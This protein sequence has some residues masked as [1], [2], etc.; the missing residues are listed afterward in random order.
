MNFDRICY[1][2]FQ[3]KEGAFCSQCGFAPQYASQYPQAL[4][5]G[6]ILGGRYITGKV[7][8]VDS[9]AISYLGYELVLEIKVVIREYF[10][11]RLA[12]RG[13]DRYAVTVS[14]D[15]E[16]TFRAGRQRFLDEA[17]ALAGIQS[18]PGIVSVR[19]QFEENNTAYI[20]TDHKEEGIRAANVP[21]ADAVKT[22]ATM[23]VPAGNA[24]AQTSYVH[25]GNAA[26]K[27]SFF[28]SL[29]AN[30]KRMALLIGA[31][32]LVVLLAVGLPLLL[33]GGEQ[34][35]SGEA[36]SPN[37]TAMPTASPLPTP[38]STPEPLFPDGQ[39]YTHP[40]IG[41]TVEVPKDFEIVTRD[42][43]FSL[44]RDATNIS[45]IYGYYS[46]D[47]CFYDLDGFIEQF[48]EIGQSLM[49]SLYGDDNA[50]TDWKITVEE[51]TTLG[52][53]RAYS[54]NV[55][56]DGYE[57]QRVDIYAISPKSGQGVYMVVVMQDLS[58][59]EA[60]RQQRENEKILHSLAVT[61]GSNSGLAVYEG[62]NIPIRFVYESK[63]RKGE[64]EDFPEQNGVVAGIWLYLDDEQD[65]HLLIED[66]SGYADSVEEALSVYN[67][68][69]ENYE[70]HTIVSRETFSFGDKE[71]EL[72]I[73][74]MK[75]GEGEQK[76][77]AFAVTEIDGR[78]YSLDLKFSDALNEADMTELITTVMLT[79]EVQS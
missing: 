28:T 71:Y 30:K 62:V 25:V 79:L 55:S 43:A 24:A 69:L 36:I 45:V 65:H 21:A 23:Y 40:A 17:R 42:Q 10:P 74:E 4:P 1:G 46:T 73:C 67:D 26:P 57:D 75:D 68:M 19:N 14:A 64:I 6:T 70:S 8:D 66:A 11:S 78:L 2:C 44:E 29:F 31:G 41:V 58:V 47:Y 51:P 18:M 13:E 52:G 5:L 15:E 32:A 37:F 16:D 9:F 39:T 54:M 12:A 7:L 61:D 63:F 50:D 34:K 77:G 48:Q 72:E 27:T 22:N 53:N 49:R 33:K 59:P 76:Y 38:E 35:E 56:A 60:E 3:E 20:V